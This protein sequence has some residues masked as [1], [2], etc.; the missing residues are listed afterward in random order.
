M[1]RVRPLKNLSLGCPD[2][3]AFPEPQYNIIKDIRDAIN[4][5][6]PTATSVATDTIAEVT[7]GSGVTI[8]GQLKPVS[9]TVALTKAMSG[10]TIILA[11]LSGNTVT[12]PAAV[13]GLTYT[14]A[15]TASLTSA[16]STITTSGTDVFKG[17]ILMKKDA[18]ADKIYTTTTANV[19]T[20]TFTTVTGGIVGST[21]TVTC[22][23]TGVWALTG[24]LIYSGT[25]ANP[26]S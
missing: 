2:V 18:T 14:F 10:S 11:T 4:T 23:A 24:S 6:L 21:V 3:K 8:T 25:V 26:L 22:I 7:S 17:A 12:L 15:R 9:S 19:I 13:V 16:T 1:S 5:N 20:E